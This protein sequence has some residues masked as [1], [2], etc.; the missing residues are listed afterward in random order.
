MKNETAVSLLLRVGIAFSFLY[1]AVQSFRDPA[2]WIGFFPVWLQDTAAPFLEAETLLLIF[3]AVEIIVALW[4]LSGWRGFWSG[5]LAAGMLGGIVGTNLG[6]L[7]ILFR[8]VPI[9]F[10]AVAYAFLSRRRN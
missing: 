1:A 3:S 8:D 10:A 2:S 6:A 4:V 9:I 7:D 5:L